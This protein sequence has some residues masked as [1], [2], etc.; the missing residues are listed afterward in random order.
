MTAWTMRVANTD[1]DREPI[2]AR[3]GTGPREESCEDGWKRDGGLIM[4][5]IQVRRMTKAD[6]QAVGD[7]LGLAF[8]DQPNTLAVTRGD[9]ALARRIAFDGM[10]VTT[11]RRTYKNMWR[12][13]RAS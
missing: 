5:G 10:R 4:D 3:R 9:V 7:I 8:A 13:A 12:E 6:E 2:V 1:A 11:L